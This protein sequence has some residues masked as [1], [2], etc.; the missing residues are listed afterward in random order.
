MGVFHVCL[1]SFVAVQANELRVIRV[2]CSV[3]KIYRAASLWDATRYMLQ[4]FN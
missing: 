4:G 1:H 3:L 2:A